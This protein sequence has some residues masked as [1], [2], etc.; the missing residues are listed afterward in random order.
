MKGSQKR[1]QVFL[2]EREALV[3]EGFS[4][5]TGLRFSHQYADLMDRFIRDLFLTAGFRQSNRPESDNA[6]A[7]VALGGYG[8]QELCLGSDVDLMVI[9]RGDLS[10]EMAEIIRHA[11]YPL[12]DAKLEVGYSILTFQECIRLA[13]TDFRMLTS[14]MDSRFFV[15]SRYF[16]R[17]YRE[18]F[19]S[20]M[21]REKDSLLGKF[22]ISR[23]ER[24]DRN[25]G[26]GCFVEPDLKEG[27]GGLRDIHLMSWMARIWFDCKRLGQMKRFAAFSHFEIRKLAASRSFLLKIRNHLHWLA[28]RK[29]D[30]LRLPYQDQISKILGYED[31]PRIS[32]PE[33]LMRD[34]YLHL[35][36]IRYRHEEFQVKMLDMI[37]PSPMESAQKDLPSEFAVLKGHIVLGE[38]VLSEMDPLVIL[39]GL[40]EANERGLFLGSGFIWEGKKIIS[41]K[42]KL[43]SRSD[44]GK[45]LFLDLILKPQN[46]EIIRLALEIGLIGL[47]IPE[48][49]KIRN[50]PQFG[51]YHVMTV[52]LHSLRT[53]DVINDITKGGYDEKWPVFKAVFEE[54]EFPDRLF[55]AALLH[56]IGKGYGEDHCIRGP[57]MIPKILS[58]LGFEKASVR[59]VSSLVRYHLLMP[60]VAQRRDLRDEKTCVQVAQA[61]QDRQLLKMLFLLSVA[62]SFATGPMA[63][64]DWKIMLLAELFHKVQRI[65]ERG[66]LAT[67][68]ATQEIE[69]KRVRIREMMLQDFEKKAVNHLIDQASSRYILNTSLQDMVAHFSLALNLG[70]RKHVWKLAKRKSASVTRII[71]VTYD[72]P[73]LF[74]KMAGV[75][76]LNNMDILSASIFTLKNGLA[77][78]TYEVTN[79]PDVYHETENWAKTQQDLRNALDERLSLDRL[80]KEKRDAKLPAPYGPQVRKKIVVNNEDSDFFTLIEIRSSARLGRLYDL[81]CVIF[82]MDLDIR[83]AKV[84]SDGEKMTGVFYVRDS[85]GEKIYEPDVIEE[86]RGRLMAVL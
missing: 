8:R 63:R 75:L 26:E 50:L 82:S 45:A 4:S 36:R 20:R 56:D 37:D 83:T 77:F 79:P 61:I 14:L 9:H 59:A 35:N 55:L 70:D 12:W 30:S 24:A 39:R 53:L 23:R 85:G 54:I 17:L 7:V 86:A 6:L 74:S 68:D 18:A 25:K 28:R 5:E 44:P 31:K 66:I 19:W 78:D 41:R 34:V 22:L 81:A 3:A 73:G 21:A 58:R 67:P 33:K 16:Y 80:I 47:F 1:V 46:P 10:S 15:G 57:Q 52:D 27:L 42:R 43:L 2:S 64:S 13:M 69:R 32:G 62:D 48:F 84:N 71:Q 60:R 76:A 49:K 72:K 65:L 51:F 40:K 11:L 29:E 38:G